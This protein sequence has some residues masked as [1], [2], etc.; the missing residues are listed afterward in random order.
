MFKSKTHNVFNE[1]VN[2]IALI[3]SDEKEL[4]TFDGAT[5]YPCGANSGNICKTE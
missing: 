4:Q 1:E 2:K 3:S 5:S